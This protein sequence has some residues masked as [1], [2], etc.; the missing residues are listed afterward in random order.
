MPRSRASVVIPAYNERAR[1]PPFLE[2]LVRLGPDRTGPAVEFLVVDDGSATDHLAAHRASV[3]E[4]SAR[5]ARSGS[6]HRVRLLEASANRGK[7]GAIRLGFAQADPE[8]SLLGFLDADGA[9]PAR[10]FWRL[11][12]LFEEGVDVLSGSRILMAG[13]AIHRST[14]RHVQGRVFATL[15]EFLLGLGFYDT[16]CG[17]KLFRAS[18]LRSCLGLLREEGWL[19]DVEILAFLKARGAHLREE[20]IDWSDPGGS[21]VRFGI[22]PLRMLV[23]LRRIRARVSKAPGASTVCAAAASPGTSGPA[24][25]RGSS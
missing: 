6:D 7:G 2:E 14:F 20:P 19:L 4:A 10:E 15:A 12:S 16:Q 17:V 24:T 23:G 18:L 9:V 21:K 22:D 25:G 3:G 5:L 11:L 13:R 1:L 8:A